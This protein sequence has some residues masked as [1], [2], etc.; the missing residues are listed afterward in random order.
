MNASWVNSAIGQRFKRLVPR[1]LRALRNPPKPPWVRA[2]EKPTNPN[3]LDDFGFYAIV[4][5]WMEAD[6]IADTVANAFT[7]GVDRVFLVDNES[8]DDTVERAT[9][10]LPGTPSQYV[11]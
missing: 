4:G 5:T 11:R 7:Q 8:P 1:R 10:H 9:N 2:M 6:V 3:P